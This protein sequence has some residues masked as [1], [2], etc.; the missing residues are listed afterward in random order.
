MK[1]SS[2]LDAEPASGRRSKPKFIQFIT[3]LDSVPAQEV[4]PQVRCFTIQIKIIIKQLKVTI[5]EEEFW[6]KRNKAV[7]SEYITWRKFYWKNAAERLRNQ[8]ELR[9]TPEPNFRPVYQPTDAW[10][11]DD[12]FFSDIYDT[13]HSHAMPDDNYSNPHDMSRYG[14]YFYASMKTSNMIYLVDHMVWTIC[15]HIYI[16]WFILKTG[17]LLLLKYFIKFIGFDTSCFGSFSVVD[18]LCPPM[19]NQ[20][21]FMDN[22]DYK[23]PVVNIEYG[24]GS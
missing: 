12:G 14:M 11:I 20:V 9:K 8:R 24:K 16:I 17:C 18:D 1:L 21:I 6:K 13:L 2:I 19:E 4:K 22:Q 5:L 15:I 23:K 7:V 3:P 10:V